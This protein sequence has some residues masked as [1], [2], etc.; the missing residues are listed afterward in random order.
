MVLGSPAAAVSVVASGCASLPGPNGCLFSGTL[1][2]AALAA[3]TQA[4]FNLFND[5]HPAAGGDIRLTYLFT[6]G[7]VGFPGSVSGLTTG[8]WA[9]PGF[10]ISYFAVNA[11]ANFALYKLTGGPSSGTWTT[12]DTPHGLNLREVRSI[13][14]MG[15]PVPEPEVWTMMI[16]GL[17]LSGVAM[18]RRSGVARVS[19]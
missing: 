2:S 6:S 12:A 18:R 3:D 9:T 16:I 15:Q 10:K 11:G 4:K 17:G 14:F 19:A 5:T 7:T 8:T 1:S 13:A